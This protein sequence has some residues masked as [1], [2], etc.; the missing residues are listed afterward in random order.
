M[1]DER[2]ARAAQDP[3]YRALVRRRGR[4][5]AGLTLVMLAAYFG[6][7]LLIAFDKPLLARPIGHGVTS[8]GIPL[9]VGIILLAVALTGLYVRRANRDYDAVTA[10]L[11]AEAGE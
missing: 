10:A 6:Y 9:G 2:L 8:L 4:F 1:R 7:V 3:R 5:A 11:R